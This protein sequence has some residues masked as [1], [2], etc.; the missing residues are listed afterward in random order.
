M[1]TKEIQ[2]AAVKLIRQELPIQSVYER[3]EDCTATVPIHLSIMRLSPQ[4][5]TNVSLISDAKQSVGQ[6]YNEDMTRHLKVLKESGYNTAELKGFE[7]F[8]QVW[9]L[10]GTIDKNGFLALNWKEDGNIHPI[11]FVEI[12]VVLHNRH[13]EHGKF[14]TPE[15]Y[16]ENRTVEI[17]YRNLSDP[18]ILYMNP[19]KLRNYGIETTIAKIDEQRGVAEVVGNAFCSDYHTN[20]AKAILLRNFAVFYLNNLLQEA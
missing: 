11:K 10:G 19:V 12:P 8:K 1:A 2:V 5:R 16:S 6:S 4:V 9:E 7:E 20:M 3:N 18:E 14:Y 17:M 15:F 13:D